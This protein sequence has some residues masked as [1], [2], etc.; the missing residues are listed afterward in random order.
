MANSP[1]FQNDQLFS[2]SLL[3]LCTLQYTEKRVSQKYSK[4][5]GHILSASQFILNYA[6][7]T[8]RSLENLKQDSLKIPTYGVPVG[9]SPKKTSTVSQIQLAVSTQK[10]SISELLRDSGDISSP[11]VSDGCSAESLEN[12]EFSIIDCS[13]AFDCNFVF[14]ERVNHSAIAHMPASVM[15]STI[16]PDV[17]SGGK[18]GIFLPCSNLDKSACRSE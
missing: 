18:S 14:S 4:K 5:I 2:I 15:R 12:R 9:Y 3:T 1:I 7:C 10:F 8:M 13:I 11:F 17:I 6:G 16:S